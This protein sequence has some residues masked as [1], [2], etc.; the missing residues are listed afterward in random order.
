MFNLK[1]PI[2]IEYEFIQNDFELLKS[3]YI[4]QIEIYD[5]NKLNFKL[6]M[7]IEVE[8]DNT[9]INI[10]KEMMST[11]NREIYLKCLQWYGL[12][13]LIATP[14]A[15]MYSVHIGRLINLC[16]AK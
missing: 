13:N 1:I 5:E 3:I 14:F 15:I 8:A 6:N 2:N 10:I 16:L 4:D 12:I 11:K 9:L 7:R